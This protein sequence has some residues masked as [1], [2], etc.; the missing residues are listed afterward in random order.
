MVHPRGCS[1]LLLTSD[2]SL[3]SLLATHRSV[4]RYPFTALSAKRWQRKGSKAQRASKR[5][6]VKR[7]ALAIERQEASPPKNYS[8]S[9][10]HSNN[11]PSTLQQLSNNSPTTLQR[12]WRVL[13]RLSNVV[14]EFSNDVGELSNVLESCWR[15]VGERW[16]APTALESCWRTRQ[17]RWRVVGIRWTVAVT[18]FGGG[19]LAAL[20]GQRSA[21][22]ASALRFAALSLSALCALFP[23]R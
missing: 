18:F 2:G 19:L 11:S 22:D 21:F 7:R 15:V 5:R 17:R 23:F 20:S 16:R 1:W 6:G 14:G 8:N 12:R 3:W 10:T 4:E 9:P 13:Q